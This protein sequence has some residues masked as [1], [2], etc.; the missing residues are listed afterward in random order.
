MLHE[1]MLTTA[2]TKLIGEAGMIREEPRK[3]TRKTT[4]PS[5]ISFTTNP[6][7]IGLKKITPPS[8]EKSWRLTSCGIACNCLLSFLSLQYK[9]GLLR[10]I[11]TRLHHINFPQSACSFTKCTCMSLV[12]ASRIW[13]GPVS[14]SLVRAIRLREVTD[15]KFASLTPNEDFRDFFFCSRLVPGS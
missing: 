7:R 1:W 5:Y 3:H 11:F 8:E 15:S 4:R 10:Q 13:S 12:R 9:S 14:N 6:T 2:G